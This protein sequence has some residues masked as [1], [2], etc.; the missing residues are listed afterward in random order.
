MVQ[1]LV[2]GARDLGFDSRASQIGH[3]VA[4]GSPPLRRFCVALA[5]SREMIPGTRYSL[6][7]NTAS[8]MTIR[9]FLEIYVTLKVSLHLFAVLWRYIDKQYLNFFKVG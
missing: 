5:L 1:D 6:R 9:F 8:I 2:I 3:S 4:N 7:R